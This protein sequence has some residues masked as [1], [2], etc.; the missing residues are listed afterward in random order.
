[1]L[2]T[3]L[4]NIAN[5]FG[6]AAQDA[7]SA[8][9]SAERDASVTDLIAFL[10]QSAEPWNGDLKTSG[11]EAAEALASLQ[12]RSSSI[13]HSDTISFFN[14]VVPHLSRIL[15]TISQNGGQVPDEQAES[16][17]ASLVNVQTIALNK[18]QG[19]EDAARQE[20]EIERDVV[21]RSRASGYPVPR[22]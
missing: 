17:R 20:M 12:E 3:L 5:G 14:R 16:L 22:I 13:H 6:C 11:M 21:K 15:T 8:V 1:M 7:V 9:R 4:G 19:I 2:R 18:I 10:R